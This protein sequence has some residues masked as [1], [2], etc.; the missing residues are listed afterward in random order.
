[1]PMIKYCE[2]NLLEMA[3]RH[4]QKSMIEA[5]MPSLA[6]EVRKLGERINR[7]YIA[8]CQNVNAQSECYRE[9]E[10]EIEPYYLHVNFDR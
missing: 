6:E 8:Y 1:M 4:A 7:E 9:I 5:R 3:C 2:L 10:K